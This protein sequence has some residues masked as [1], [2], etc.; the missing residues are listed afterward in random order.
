M[1]LPPKIVKNVIKKSEEKI[2]SKIIYSFYIISV[3]DD[4]AMVIR[5]GRKNLLKECL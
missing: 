3:L 1:G 2:A 4:I 5:F